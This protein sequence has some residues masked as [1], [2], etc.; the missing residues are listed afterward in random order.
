MD[1]SR[2]CQRHE[3]VELLSPAAFREAFSKTK[4]D[5]THIVFEAGFS[6]YLD[7]IHPHHEELCSIL[8]I[9]ALRKLRCDL[10]RAKAGQRLRP[11]HVIDG[12]R[13]HQFAKCCTLLHRAGYV[14]I[15]DSMHL[16]RTAKP[17][18]PKTSDEI[19]LYLTELYPGF[20]ALTCLIQHTG[21]HLA[22]IWSNRTNGVRV[23]FGTPE[24]QKLAEQVYGSD[25]TSKAFHRLLEHFMKTL[26]D[27]IAVGLSSSRELRLL[28]LGAGT[29]GT[30]KWLAP[31]IKNLCPE[32]TVEYMFTDIS[33]TMVSQAQQSFGREYSF[34]SFTTHDIETPPPRNL[35]QRQ[36]IVIIVN[37]VH[38]TSDIV[39][40]L[41]N[42][43]QF[44][45]PEGGIVLM[46]E[47]MEQTCWADFI[48]GFFEGWWRFNDRRTHALASVSE[49]NEAFL[50]A[51]FSYVNWTEGNCRDSGFQKLF[52]ASVR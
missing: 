41:R 42:I 44:L 50:E 18:P 23:I 30:T 32:D 2:N 7:I 20:K 13:K 29:G 52:I 15:S 4:N 36:D 35:S 16:I 40:S 8:I 6:G 17:I 5:T 38:A 37:A 3:G 22:E 27:Q 11:N 34:M 24:G 33:G 28:E 10:R 45:R 25:C 19:A 31:L 51:G 26:L 12:V 49:W 46:L 1:T 43:R 14:E 47:I 9:E 21:K 48:F 39:Q